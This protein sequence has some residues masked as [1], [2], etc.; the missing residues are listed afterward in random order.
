MASTTNTTLIFPHTNPHIGA[1]IV[2]TARLGNKAL[3]SIIY[4]F[5]KS[6]YKTDKQ[7]DNEQERKPCLI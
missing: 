1:H 7:A 2:Y 3:V 5:S 4:C 6:M